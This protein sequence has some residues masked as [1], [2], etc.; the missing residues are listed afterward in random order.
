MRRDKHHIAAAAAYK[1]AIAAGKTVDEAYR[2]RGIAY[3]ASKEVR[4]REI[5]EEKAKHAIQSKTC[6]IC[7]R[8][9][10]AEVGLIAHHG[11]ER[12]AGAGWQTESCF[13]ARALPYEADREQ[14]GVWIVSCREAERRAAAYLEKVKKEKVKFIVEWSGEPYDYV[15]CEW[16]KRSVEV[17]R[18]T[19]AAVAAANP[20]MMAKRRGKRN[21]KT[22]SYTPLTFNDVKAAEVE[23]A[24]GKLDFW[25]GELLRQAYRWYE[26]RKTYEW[27]GTTWSKIV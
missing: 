23:E 9:I 20:E 10:F 1:A 16:P 7:G 21:P 24:K 19:F 18:A 2:A 8:P 13:G 17:T 5:A 27:S 25:A 11:Y 4:A 12:P 26:W 15:R 6:Q 14:L 3:R 22:W